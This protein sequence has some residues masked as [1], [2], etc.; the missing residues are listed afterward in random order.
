VLSFTGG[1]DGTT[2][3]DEQRRRCWVLGDLRAR[4]LAV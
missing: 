3:A 2:A 1:G 4:V